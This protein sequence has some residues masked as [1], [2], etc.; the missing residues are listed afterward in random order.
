MTQTKQYTIRLPKMV[1]DELDRYVNG[2][3]FRN[4]QH[5][6]LMIVGDWLERQRTKGKGE[7]TTFLPIKPPTRGKERPKK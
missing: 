2:Q 4:N 3:T 6:F 1:A 5:A 7:Q